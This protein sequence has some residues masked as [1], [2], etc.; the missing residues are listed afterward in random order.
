MINEEAYSPIIRRM[1]SIMSQLRALA[2]V[3]E[4]AAVK[5]YDKYVVKEMD[6]AF[7]P[8]LSGLSDDTA[9]AY[10]RKGKSKSNER[11]AELFFTQSKD[12]DVVAQPR[13][14]TVRVGNPTDTGV[15]HNPLPMNRRGNVDEMVNNMSSMLESSLQSNEVTNYADNMEPDVMLPQTRKTISHISHPLYD[16]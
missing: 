1:E 7:K 10:R 13:S 14:T 4:D 15:G 16:Q 5:L 3:D 11:A 8:V 9:K 6:K 2:Y 12:V